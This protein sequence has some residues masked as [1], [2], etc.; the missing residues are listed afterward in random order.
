MVVP[1]LAVN[2]TG[3]CPFGAPA[4]PVGFVGKGGAR[5]RTPFLPKAEAESSG[6]CDDAVHVCNNEKLRILD[7]SVMS[8]RPPVLGG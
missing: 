3:S 8:V 4:K 1:H 2:S 6:L 5:E 7:W